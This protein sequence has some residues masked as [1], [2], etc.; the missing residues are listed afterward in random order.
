[1]T[2]GMSIE[3]FTILHVALS[4]AGLASGL[5]VLLGLLIGRPFER[6]TAVF[7]GTTVLTSLTGFGFPVDRVLPSHIVGALSLVV[8]AA[9]ILARDRFGPKGAWR[10]TYVICAAVALYFNAFVGVVQAFLRVPALKALAPKQNEPPFVTAQ[11]L[12]L[13]SFVI[14]GSLAARRTRGG[15]HVS[16]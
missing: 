1:M 7:L 13:V 4:L 3:G 5:V 6:W 8:L 15:L 12:L 11:A 10:R 9:A 14:L 16:S 2:L